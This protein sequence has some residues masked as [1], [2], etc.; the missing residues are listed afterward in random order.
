MDLLECQQLEGALSG[1]LHELSELDRRLQ[2]QAE[3]GLDILVVD[4]ENPISINVKSL[5]QEIR[6]LLDELRKVVQK[7]SSHNDMQ[8]LTPSQKIMWAEF[9]RVHSSESEQF[10]RISVAVHHKLDNAALMA[11]VLGD[12]NGDNS[13]VDWLLRERGR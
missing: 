9:Q 12:K 5:E 3:E 4:E 8:L 10:R 7:Y 13:S 1:K 6:G 11:N 2:Q